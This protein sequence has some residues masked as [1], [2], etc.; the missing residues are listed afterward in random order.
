MRVMDNDTD[1]DRGTSIFPMLRGREKV[2]T[3]V[4]SAPGVNP[5][6]QMV[7]VGPTDANRSDSP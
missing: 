4:C 7:I 3:A 1:R 6:S 2:S 5:T